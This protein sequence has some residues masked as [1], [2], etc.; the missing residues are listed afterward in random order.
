MTLPLSPS[1]SPSP[2][3]LP[4]PPIP[5]DGTCPQQPYK[6]ITHDQ[7]EIEWLG[8]A[9][10]LQRYLT[11]S[12]EIHQRQDDSSDNGKAR[13]Q[14]GT[15]VWVLQS[16]GRQ[17][18]KFNDK[19]TCN[20][21]MLH[22][23]RRDKKNKRAMEK[24]LEKGGYECHA[25]E[26]STIDNKTEIIKNITSIDNMASE[27]LEATSNSSYVYHSKSEMFLRARVV[28]DDDPL[29]N[30]LSF[31]KRMQRRV[32]VR[33]SKGATYRVRAYNLLPVVEQS[34]QNMNSSSTELPSNPN[35][36]D[37][38]ALP[39]MVIVTPE[40]H[41]YRRIAKTHTTPDDSFMEIGCDYG[42]TVDKIRKAMEE[43][44]DVPL[45]WPKVCMDGEADSRGAPLQNLTELHLPEQQEDKKVLC[46]GVDR[47]KESIDIANE[48]FPQCKFALCN[49]LKAEEMASLNEICQQTLKGGAP[50]V[51]A[52]DVNGN[53]EIEGVLQCLQMVM[54][55]KWARQP[56]LIVVK[57]R[58]LY[59]DLKK[60]ADL[61]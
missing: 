58:F 48:R 21:L 2:L 26:A 4:Q 61:L 39:P 17:N 43:A 19:S 6:Y 37:G 15:L 51:I 28:S 60:L 10:T 5:S 38:F 16:K 20:S 46:L 56:R 1:M 54:N 22:K 29:E 45:L 55:E 9:S 42:I 52:I 47:S 53:R 30:D 27:S 23:K 12:Q 34:L 35:E 44:G 25:R 32:L 41:I 11:E 13:Y 57:S 14:P 36:V 33:Y 24:C 49:V 3:S 8:S 7:L 18:S 59:W 50:S 31:E 40:T